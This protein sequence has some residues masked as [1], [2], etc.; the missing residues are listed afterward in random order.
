[1]TLE[2]DSTFAPSHS[3]AP[4][5]RCQ[6]L[7]RQR[8]HWI[9][10]GDPSRRQETRNQARDC[11]CDQDTREHH[12]IVWID[13]IENGLQRSRCEPCGTEAERETNGELDDALAHHEQDQLCTFRSECRTHS[14][15]ARALR[16]RKRHD[17]VQPGGGERQYLYVVFYW[18]RFWYCWPWSSRC[19]C[20]CS[21]CLADSFSAAALATL[22]AS[23]FAF[24][25][26]AFSC[27]FRA[28]FDIGVSPFSLS[29]DLAGVFCL[30]LSG[31]GTPFALP[32]GNPSSV[33]LFDFLSGRMNHLDLVFGYHRSFRRMFA[34]DHELGSGD[35]AEMRM[36]HPL[37]LY[38]KSYGG[39]ECSLRWSH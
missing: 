16:H 39:E 6:L 5:Y 34:A 25:R 9:D 20:D 19:R 35:G 7:R 29:S 11:E 32:A 23:F 15:F 2:S 31:F 36:R 13:V 38:V 21:F 1:M 18:L 26:S 12:G 10:L 27:F 17:A 8:E 28:F 3:D 33:L 37:D 22:S 30:A 4:R 24:A 14:H